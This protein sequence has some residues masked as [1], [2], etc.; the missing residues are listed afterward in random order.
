MNPE[1]VDGVNR[2]GITVRSIHTLEG[3]HYSWRVSWPEN[4][5]HMDLVR[6]RDGIR[7]NYLPALFSSF[8]WCVADNSIFIFLVFYSL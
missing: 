7:K 5:K 6:P 1:G 2:K 3:I 4:E 8:T